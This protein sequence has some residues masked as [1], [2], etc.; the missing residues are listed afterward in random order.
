MDTFVDD[1]KEFQ[2]IIINKLS[3]EGIEHV[4][5]LLT[6]IT[7]VLH[8]NNDALK[9]LYVLGEIC[10]VD[11]DFEIWR[12]KTSALNADG[13]LFRIGK[14]ENYLD[15][16]MTKF[17]ASSINKFI[18]D[19]NKYDSLKEINKSQFEMTLLLYSPIRVEFF[20]LLKK[21]EY[22]NQRKIREVEFHIP[23]IYK[24]I[25]KSKQTYCIINKYEYTFYDSS[26]V[27]ISTKEALIHEF[28][29]E[30]NIEFELLDEMA[31]SLVSKI[32]L[33]TAFKLN[34]INSKAFETL[35]YVFKPKSIDK[36]HEM[37]KLYREV[38]DD[39]IIKKS[40]DEFLTSELIE[41]SDFLYKSKDEK[42]KL[43]CSI[44]IDTFILSFEVQNSLNAN[45]KRKYCTNEI[46]KLSEI[47]CSI[48][49]K[50]TKEM[51][52]FVEKYYL[53]E[54][55]TINKE[56]R[57]FFRLLFFTIKKPINLIDLRNDMSSQKFFK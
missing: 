24:E 32:T 50:N 23:L 56:F 12:L 47:K 41:L 9:K 20:E 52:K 44:I 4:F 42:A 7:M 15:N 40:A 49:Q 30:L 3:R 55:L 25:A 38:H 43:L 35:Y 28:A 2:T 6:Y 36:W 14:L 18:V 26:N 27:V 31:A 17:V 8:E 33:L 16:E 34:E 1:A 11:I 22:N 39:N 29:N 48:Y 19:K 10:K 53:M 54:K 5:S 37:T 51:Q 57:R 46:L 21:S 45:F 13:Y